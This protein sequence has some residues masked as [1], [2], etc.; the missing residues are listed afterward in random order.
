MRNREVL[1]WRDY[2]ARVIGDDRQVDVAAR[3]G[4]DQTTIS[5]WLSSSSSEPPRLSPHSVAA[6]A[7]GY[8]QNVLEAYVVAGFLTPEETGI[9]VPTLIDLTK[10]SAKD[11]AAEIRRRLLEAG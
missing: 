1:G 6:F 10:V 9:T 4:I 11:L 3:T 5:R 7:R 8:G 2:V